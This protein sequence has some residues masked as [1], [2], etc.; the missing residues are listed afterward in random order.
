MKERKVTKRLQI[1]REERDE[2]LRIQCNF[3]G[4]VALAQVEADDK[5]TESFV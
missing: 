5:I 2:R 1:E 3:K 4:E